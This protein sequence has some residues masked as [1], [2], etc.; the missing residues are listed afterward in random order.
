[1]SFYS[2]LYVPTLPLCGPMHPLG[3]G[4]NQGQGQGHLIFSC[5]RTYLTFVW[6]NAS[7][8]M[9]V[10]S[11]S[12]SRSPYILLY[13]YLPY[14][15]VKVTLPYLSDGQAESVCSNAQPQCTHRVQKPLS[16]VLANLSIASSSTFLK[17]QSLVGGIQ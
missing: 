12:R 17:C 8:W 6:P 10:E 13:M 3:C 14:L 16:A 5:I 11:R 9:R 1:M 4:L 15:K 7:T 2:L